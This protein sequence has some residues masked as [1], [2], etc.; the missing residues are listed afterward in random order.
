[1]AEIAPHLCVLIR[2]VL[3]ERFAARGWDR[4]PP[5][6]DA[7]LNL[8]FVKYPDLRGCCDA[9]FLVA[10][11]F[12]HCV[13]MERGRVV[14]L[15]SRMLGDLAKGLNPGP[16]IW[17][18]I[19]GLDLDRAA[20]AVADF[21]TAG[22]VPEGVRVIDLFD[23]FGGLRRFPQLEELLYRG[24]AL[25]LEQEHGRVAHLMLRL[26]RDLNSGGDHIETVSAIITGVD[27]DQTISR[28]AALAIAKE[29]PQYSNVVQLPRSRN[30]TMH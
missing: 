30:W 11:G 13:E 22:R 21:E 14:T 28:A 25:G 6:F 27:F 1:M 19:N 26:V 5:I 29:F 18:I 23:D 4:P 7:G 16:S 15:L 2:E 9:Q 8:V 10:A 12:L 24:F 17:E 3:A 20:E